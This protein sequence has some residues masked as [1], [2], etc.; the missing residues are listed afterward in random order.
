MSGVIRLADHA[1][2]RSTDGDLDAVEGAIRLV[3]CGAARRVVL[4]NLM[5][6]AGVLPRVV[7]LGQRVGVPVRGERSTG[8]LAIVV[9][10]LP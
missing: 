1:R 9:G 4:V 2:H 8:C 3:A 7:A 10:P 5:D 6:P